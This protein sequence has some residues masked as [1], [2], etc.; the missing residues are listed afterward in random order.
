MVTT[1]LIWSFPIPGEETETREGKE[2]HTVYVKYI[3][4]VC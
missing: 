2:L 3:L 4:M 1:D